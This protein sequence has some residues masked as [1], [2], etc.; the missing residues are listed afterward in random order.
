MSGPDKDKEMAE[1]VPETGGGYRTYVAAWLFLLLLTAVTVG[2]YRL[3]LGKAGAAIAVAVASVK[4]GLILIYFMHL[5]QE[6]RFLQAV[7]L[8]PVL[9]IGVLIGFTYLDVWYR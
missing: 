3:H 8:I 2:V 5:R 4:A 6:G 1:T 9:L 7:F